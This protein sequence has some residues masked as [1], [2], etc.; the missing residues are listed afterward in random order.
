MPKKEPGLR[1]TEG[2]VLSVGRTKRGEFV[3][4]WT[5]EEKEAPYP[6]THRESVRM[7]REEAQWLCEELARQLKIR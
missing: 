5:C 7:S 3:V 2:D 6:F 1:E 4:S